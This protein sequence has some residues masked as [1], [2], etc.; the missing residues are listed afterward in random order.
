M[1]AT[2]RWRGTNRYPRCSRRLFAQRLVN[3]PGRTDWDLAAPPGR[4]PRKEYRNGEAT[5]DV[6]RPRPIERR[7]VSAAASLFISL[8]RPPRP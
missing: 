6:L 4:M 7:E 3:N 5:S 1:T 8:A 2:E